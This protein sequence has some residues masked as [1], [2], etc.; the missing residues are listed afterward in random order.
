[1]TEDWPAPGPIPVVI[2]QLMKLD[3]DPVT[4]SIATVVGGLASM[5]ADEAVWDAPPLLCTLE[6]HPGRMMPY[7]REVMQPDGDV[8]DSVAGFAQIVGAGGLPTLLQLKGQARPEVIGWLLVVEAWMLRN[9]SPE[10]S[11]RVEQ[12]ERIAT[13][14]DR[15]EVRLVHAVDRVRAYFSAQPRDGAPELTVES[16]PDARLEGR[17]IN[18]LR[19]LM[20]ATPV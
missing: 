18:A 3:V 9:P 10:D 2:G 4:V 5:L 17:L 8:P 16:S 20:E 12:G 7:V 14:P 1:M 6:R 15:V 19:D 11:A 13:M